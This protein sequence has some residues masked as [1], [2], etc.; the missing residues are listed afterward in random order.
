MARTRVT[1]AG[2][3]RVSR[4]IAKLK[5]EGKTTKEAAGA[6]YGMEREKRL[7]PKGGYK[8]GKKGKW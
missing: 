1:K 3:R 2:Q 7:G 8:R 4:K 5:R 6:A